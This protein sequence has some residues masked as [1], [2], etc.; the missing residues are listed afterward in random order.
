MPLE[1]PGEGLTGA[2]GDELSRLGG[3]RSTRVRVQLA[4]STTRAYGVENATANAAGT[5]ITLSGG[6]EFPNQVVAGDRFR[7][8]SESQFAPTVEAVIASVDSRTQITLTTAAFVGLKN[9]SWE[10]FLIADQM[11]IQVETTLGWPS[12]GTFVMDGQL[13]RYRTLAAQSFGTIERFN[14]EVWTFAVD[15]A[16]APGEELADYSRTY[17]ALDLMWRS[18]LVDYATGEDLD[19]VGRNLGVRRPDTLVADATYRAV[20][21]ALA[22]VPRGTI[23][24]IELLLTALVGK[25]NFEIFED[26]TQGVQPALPRTAAAGH[27]AQIF[28][29]VSDSP[30][31]QAGKTFLEGYELRPM[32]TATTVAITRMPSTIAGVRLAPEGKR[33]VAAS[34]GKIAASNTPDTQSI[35]KKRVQVTYTAGTDL[36]TVTLLGTETWPI[37]QPLPGDQMR[38]LTAVEGGRLGSVLRLVSDSVIEIAAIKGHPQLSRRVRRPL[39]QRVLAAIERLQQ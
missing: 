17:S 27:P 31:R 21:K 29:R 30:T 4:A 36:L 26:L 10:I 37:G 7:V 2:L 14:G 32:A 1:G 13:W 12:S 39:G 23:W 35:A 33:R 3:Y 24:V 19:I 28:I 38:V 15:K 18:F 5:I 22:Y 6:Q 16:Y 20:I 25:G 11:T 34:G 9:G 8:L